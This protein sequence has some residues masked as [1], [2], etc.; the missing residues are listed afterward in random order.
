MDNKTAKGHNLAILEIFRN[1]AAAMI[2]GSTC[3]PTET[4]EWCGKYVLITSFTNSPPHLIRVILWE[5][6][7]IGWHYEL[8]ALNQALNPHP[9][10]D[11]YTEYLSF[12]QPLFLDSSG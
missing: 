4:V 11:Y 10:A 1:V 6:Y 3:P 2:Q 9:W 5:I 8:C 7:E 12:M